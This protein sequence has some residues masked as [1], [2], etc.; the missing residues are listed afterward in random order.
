MDDNLTTRQ[1]D[2]D[3]RLRKETGSGLVAWL[4]E[5]RTSPPKPTPFVAISRELFDTTGD[6]VSYES[7]RQ[8]CI[9]FHISERNGAAA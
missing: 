7:L 2:I 9:D 3:R 4:T 8:W 5:H 6:S 1:A